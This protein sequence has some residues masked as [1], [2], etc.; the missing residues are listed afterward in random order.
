MWKGKTD[1]EVLEIVSESDNVREV[2]LKV[3]EN[4]NPP[5]ASYKR[6]SKLM[7]DCGIKFKNGEV[8]IHPSLQSLYEEKKDLQP[9]IKFTKNEQSE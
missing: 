4:K 1:I 8:Y 5:S 9:T 3:Y 6:I 7:I 2:L